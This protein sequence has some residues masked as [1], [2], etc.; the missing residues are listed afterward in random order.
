MPILLQ[1]PDDQRKDKKAATT[2]GSPPWIEP[3]SLVW[4][5][6]NLISIAGQSFGGARVTISANGFYFGEAMILAD[7]S[8]KVTGTINQN[9]QDNALE[10]ILVN[11]SGQAVSQYILPLRSR[12]L[13][14]G[15]DGS[16]LVVVNEGDALWRIA[17]RSF[18]EGVR[19]VDIVRK[20]A[21]DIDNPDLIF[22]NQIF[23]LPK[24]IEVD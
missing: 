4:Q 2:A 13:K 23:A 17:Y 18:G 15:L 14:K 6:D 21:N 5:K 16:K 8:W 1:S 19:Y 24:N 20:N 12:D 3:R 7:G 22:P 10:F 9:Q 11:N